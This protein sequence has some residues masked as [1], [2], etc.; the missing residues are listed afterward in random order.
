MDIVVYALLRK[1]VSDSLIGIGALKGAP[2]K[3]A[4]IVDNSDGTH[5]IT[6]LWK[7]DLG[8][9]HTSVLTVSN[10]ETP[11]IDVTAI[12]G[13]HRVTF[14]TNSPAQS[15]TVDIMDGADGKDGISVTNAQVDPDTQHLIVTLSDGTEID[16]GEVKGTT[17]LSELD[18]IDINT[19]T[20]SNGDVLVYN[21]ATGK[22]ENKELG[23]EA[24]LDD[25][26]DVDIDNLTLEN[27]SILKYN[28]TTHKWENGT[29]P[30]IESLG[31]IDD[32][33]INNPANGQVLKYDETTQRWVNANG[34]GG[35]SYT[36]GNGINIDVNNVISTDEVIFVGTQAAWDA[37]TTEEKNAYDLVN[38]IGDSNVIDLSKYLE[39][40]NV[41][42]TPSATYLGQQRLYVGETDV[43]V[44]G[45]IYECQTVSGTDP[46]EYQWVAIS[47]AELPEDEFVGT[48]AEWDALTEEEQNQYTIVNI[49]GDG[50]TLNLGVYLEKKASMPVASVDVLNKVYLYIGSTTQDYKKGVMY[51]CVSDGAVSPTYRWEAISALEDVFPYTTPQDFGA[52]GDGVTDDSD[53]MAAFF[54]S[55]EKILYIPEG[56]YLT[57]FHKM[58]V[59]SFGGAVIFG[60]GSTKSIIKLKNTHNG[61]QFGNGITLMANN[62][63]PSL[64]MRDLALVY[65]NDDNSVTYPNTS[66]VFLYG[67]GDFDQIILDNCYFH[68]GGTATTLPGDNLVWFKCGANN[69]RVSNCLFENFSNRDIG[70]CL[71]FNAEDDSTSPATDRAIKQISVIDNE[72]RNTNR[73]EAL[74]I[75]KLTNTT[76]FHIDAIDIFNNTFN[77][78]DWNGTCHYTD[79]VLTLFGNENDPQTY[80]GNANI[81]GNDFFINECKEDG[82]RIKRL[83]GV[84]FTNNK[85]IIDGISDDSC[86]FINVSE[87][88]PDFITVIK[89]N[90]FK[91]TQ[92]SKQM[93]VGAER[94]NVQFVNN[95]YES[96][97]DLYINNITSR[98][99][100]NFVFDFI[101]NIFNLSNNKFVVRKAYA[102]CKESFIS[103]QI[104]GQLFFGNLIGDGI[105]FKKNDFYTTQTSP[106]AFAGTDMVWEYN[107]GVMLGISNAY[108]QTPM[109]SFRYRGEK[110]S[111]RFA[112]NSQSVE[113][114]PAVRAQ[115]FTNCDI[116]YLDED[117]TYTAGTGIDITNN[118]VSLDSTTQG[119]LNG[120]GTASTKDS[121]DRVSPNNTALVES[122]S[123]YS[124]INTAL[125]S[126]YTPAGEITCAELTSSLLISDNIGKVYELSDAGTTT[127]LF[128]QGAGKPLAI[129]DNV[130]IISAGQGRILF[131]L[132]ANR[133]DLSTFQKKALTTPLTVGGVSQTTVEGVLSG[134]NGLVPSG[135]TPLNKLVNKSGLDDYM[136]HNRTRTNDILADALNITKPTIL[137]GSGTAYT[138][139]V[140]YSALKYAIFL[141]IPRGGDRFVIGWIN[142]AIAVN[143]H[144][145]TSWNGWSLHEAPTSSVTRDGTAPV[146]S[147]AVYS[148][149]QNPAKWKGTVVTEDADTK[150]TFFQKIVNTFG[151]CNSGDWITIADNAA[152]FG[153]AAGIMVCRSDRLQ[154]I[155]V[156]HWTTSGARIYFINCRRETAQDA[157][158]RYVDFT[159]TTEVTF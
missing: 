44:K 137:E 4:S 143:N 144:N 51:Q 114:T 118:T 126:I 151:T 7:D 129:G 159:S 156:P 5:D 107:N 28:A 93:T 97:S 32:V 68:L 85:M 23:I 131:N 31:D 65:D 146:T 136:W 154:G 122:Q 92:A 36:A 115:F 29:I 55:G 104:H 109:N 14:T 34:G 62:S 59:T 37:L 8:V 54:K 26:Q 101:N 21:A 77:H 81:S 40:T 57:D 155:L 48:Q 25:L 153:Y 133:I 45:T 79:G 71:W 119:I 138:G 102:N 108:I 88:S 116:V 148:A 157:T 110:S 127:A 61:G 106:I 42:P 11:N 19:T 41:M 90:Y 49:T 50:D 113:D 134:L 139:T 1:F 86:K 145:S 47:T 53:A 66:M 91:L 76:P 141:V 78:K 121:T 46:V 111:L 98:S 149:I 6:W 43:Y 140:P 70:G 39:K 87:I 99:Q 132:M 64:E 103:N 73:D 24:K 152:K 9:N 74:A 130:G 125:S 22:W 63:K 82:V 67:V 16:C 120:L 124:A 13:G 15:E 2:C 135:T 142:G 56:T 89:D 117:T 94:S 95:V 18:E 3:I 20:L 100:D 10:G 52:V 158:L 96:A 123:V 80:N 83:S 27:G 60:D 35:G 12:A 150:A 38:I 72:F 105:T 30:N 33:N 69:I 58:R 84:L 128:L 17:S 75:W 147:G 112:V